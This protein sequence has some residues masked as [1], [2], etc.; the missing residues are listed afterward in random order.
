[1]AGWVGVSGAIASGKTAV[2]TCLAEA[3]E[4]PVASF[5]SYVRAEAGRR[6]VP[7]DRRALQDLGEAL[8]GAMGWEAFCL[9]VLEHGGVERGAPIA[10]IDGIRHVSALETL[11]QIAAPTAFHLVFLD[12]EASVRQMRLEAGG[13]SIQDLPTIENHPTEQQV[14]AA[15]RE[16][17]VVVVSGS[18]STVLCRDARAALQRLQ[19]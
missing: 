10:V 6:G 19:L 2:A 12:V 5:G 18:D 11:E 14:G 13:V 1:M 3:F 4:A 15:L 16:L 8:I 9:A 17:A 7:G